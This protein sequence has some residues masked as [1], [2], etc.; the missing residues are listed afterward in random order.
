MKIYDEQNFELK[1]EMKSDNNKKIYCSENCLGKIDNNLI[2]FIRDNNIYINEILD[3]NEY[4]TNQIIKF[5]DGDLSIDSLYAI[6]NTIYASEGWE[7]LRSYKKIE[8]EFIEDKKDDNDIEAIYKEKFYFKDWEIILGVQRI[9]TAYFGIYL[10]TKKGGQNSF[11]HHLVDSASDC[12]FKNQI[13]FLEP[14][15]IIIGNQKQLINLRD[16]EDG[17]YRLKLHFVSFSEEDKKDKDYEQRPKCRYRNLNNNSFL[18]LTDCLS[19]FNII[20]ENKFELYQKRKDIKGH[21]FEIKDDL[22]FILNDNNLL[23]YKFSDS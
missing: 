9:R 1:I 12:Y 23:I 5:C 20:N 3:S 22:L 16:C 15:Y 8:D 6:E 10:H 13:L 19:Q 11:Q 14:S 2:F 17:D 7:V 18:Y 4:Q 21:Y